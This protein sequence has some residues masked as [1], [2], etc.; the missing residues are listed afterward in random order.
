[1]EPWDDTQWASEYN[2]EATNSNKKL[3]SA[4]SRN[5]RDSVYSPPVRST[6]SSPRQ[7]DL[8]LGNTKEIPA[9]HQTNT[10]GPFGE[11]LFSS[12]YYFKAKRQAALMDEDRANVMLRNRDIL[13]QVRTYDWDSYRKRD[14][15]TLFLISTGRLRG[16]PNESPHEA[17]RR[18]HTPQR[19]GGTRSGPLHLVDVR[20]TVFSETNLANL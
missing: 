7:E 5:H 20:K 11:R 13:N 18:L 15:S 17:V 10:I 14:H 19:P 1:L 4:Q 2:P 12:E 16:E 6:K 9:A 3:T 8:T